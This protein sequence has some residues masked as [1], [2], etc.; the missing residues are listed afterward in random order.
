MNNYWLT[1]L[2]IFVYLILKNYKLLALMESKNPLI[3]YTL[4]FL[5][6][7]LIYSA[8]AYFILRGI[9]FVWKNKKRRN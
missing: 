4:F 8:L 2:I 3:P 7:G 1:T 9:D 6:T 5:F